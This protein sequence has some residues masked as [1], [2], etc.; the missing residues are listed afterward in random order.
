MPPCICWMQSRSEL[1]SLWMVVS[2][3]ARSFCKMQ[4]NQDMSHW[5][6]SIVFVSKHSVATFSCKKSFCSNILNV[7]SSCTHISD[8]KHWEIFFSPL[9]VH[10][11]WTGNVIFAGSFFTRRCEQ[12]RSETFLQR[13]SERSES[14]K[15]IS[16]SL[17]KVEVEHE[18]M[19]SWFLL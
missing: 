13:K 19:L 8:G 9:N 2:H 18:N 4:M 10:K 7:Y 16:L 5:T 14:F 6:R 1:K 11:R 12:K 3:P 17:L 15:G